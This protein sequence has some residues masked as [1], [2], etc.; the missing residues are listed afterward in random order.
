MKKLSNLLLIIAA[1]AFVFVACEGPEG[2]D[3]PTGPAGE[4]GLTGPQGDTGADGTTTCIECHSDD[5]SLTAKA[6][7]WEASVHAYGG[8]FERNEDRCAICHTSQG[9]IARVAGT[10]PADI[11][12]PTSINCYTCHEI[13]ETF[14]SDDIALRTVAPVSFMA[15]GTSGTEDADANLCMSCHQVTDWYDIPNA[16]AHD[17][18]T[19]MI[20]GYWGPHHGS[21]GNVLNGLAAVEFTGALTITSGGHYSGDCISCHNATSGGTLGTRTRY[22][23]KEYTYPKTGRTAN[24]LVT[25]SHLGI[26]DE[27]ISDADTNTILTYKSI[28]DPNASLEEKARSYLDLNCAYCHRSGTGNRGEFP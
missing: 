9:F 6:L 16:T 13:H 28:D 18:A 11:M 7:Q 5:Q 17:T 1:A 26:L 3:G 23:N 2:P 24:Q 20:N 12:D 22:L 15:G 19:V 10:A 14:T 21:Q 4:T 25:L 8:T 27:V